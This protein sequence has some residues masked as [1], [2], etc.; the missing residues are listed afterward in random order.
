MI[1]FVAATTKELR[2][3]IREEL[4]LSIL[5][6]PGRVQRFREKD[7]AFLTCGVGPINAA[8][9]LEKCLSVNKKI[10]LVVNVGIAGSYD[11]Q[12]LPLGSVCAAVKEV[13]PE[14]G[15]RT[16]EFFADPKL[17]GFPLD[18]RGK[19]QVWNSL[20]LDINALTQRF[21]LNLDPA[22]STG[23]SITLAGVSSGPEQAGAFKEYF[24]ADMENMEG[25]ALAYCCYLRSVSFAEIRSIS[26]L[27]GSRNKQEWD[28]LSAFQS[29]GRIWSGLW[30]RNYS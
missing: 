4:P 21:G 29:L 24:K 16:S 10:S 7:I 12:S 28:I 26:N 11:L 19:A 5:G 25:F 2:H 8:I 20:P 9:N 22:W 13:W 17:L 6:Q 1:L 3:F 30:G 15:V 14:Y 23:V 18:K 27:A